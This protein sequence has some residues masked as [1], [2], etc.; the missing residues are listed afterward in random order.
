MALR[1]EETS[2]EEMRRAFS[3]GK[4][5]ELF[6]E[7]PFFAIGLSGANDPIDPRIHSFC[8]NNDKNSIIRKT[9]DPLSHFIQ[10]RVFFIRSNQGIGIIKDCNGE[11]K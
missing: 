11:I 6:I 2:S 9:D 5:F 1:A 8:E 4:F 3:K 7:H 10:S